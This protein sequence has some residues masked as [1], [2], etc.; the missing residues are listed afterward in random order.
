VLAKKQP[1]FT[2]VCVLLNPVPEFVA[3]VS[4]GTQSP[5]P[6]LKLCL[7]EMKIPNYNLPSALLGN[8]TIS[9][10]TSK[11]PLHSNPQESM[12]SLHPWEGH[13]YCACWIQSKIQF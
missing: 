10:W 4:W 13:R 3:A 9:Q 12:I 1:Q 6:A 2:V 8:F 5:H 7:S 11:Y